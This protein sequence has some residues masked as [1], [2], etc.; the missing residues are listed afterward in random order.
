MASRTR[1]QRAQVETDPRFPS[2]K[3][4]GFWLQ[5]HFVG[6]Q[7]M[8]L[9]LTFANGVVRGGGADRVGD[10]TMSGNYDLKNGDCSLVKCYDGAHSVV[11]EGR[12]EGDGLWIWGLWNIRN[13]DRGGFHLWPEGEDD[14]TGRKLKEVKDV[15]ADEKRVRL[16]PVGTR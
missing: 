5:Q 6:R 15:P 2:G 12:N 13:F 8:N 4:V 11:Y 3:W 14:P 1:K 7:Y 10:F 16:E 9:Q